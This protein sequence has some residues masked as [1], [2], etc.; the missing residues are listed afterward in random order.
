MYG[1][2]QREQVSVCVRA[3]V[4]VHLEETDKASTLLCASTASAVLHSQKEEVDRG[5][6]A[7]PCLT[8]PE[9]HECDSLCKCAHVQSFPV[10][11]VDA[12]S[13]PAVDARVIVTGSYVP[14]SHSFFVPGHVGPWAV[15]VWVDL[16]STQG[17][18]VR[19][20]LGGLHGFPSIRH[21]LW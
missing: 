8:E 3:F 11:D 17:K 9:S 5:S 21:S 19:V 7:N 4:C 13:D 14:S 12:C 1:V 15:G 20:V 10:V 2:L 6:R 18:G 16:P